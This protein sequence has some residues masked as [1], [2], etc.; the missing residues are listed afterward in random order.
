MLV[1]VAAVAALDLSFGQVPF[2]EFYLNV[3]RNIAD[4]VAAQYGSKPATAYL[5][6]IEQHWGYALLLALALTI[7]EVK[8][9]WLYLL[10]VGAVLLPL[11]A[12]EH[13]EYRFYYPAT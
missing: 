5:E 7:C 4:G 8:R 6:W 2:F 1:A 11:I 10:V 3:M 13:K 12:I 9:T